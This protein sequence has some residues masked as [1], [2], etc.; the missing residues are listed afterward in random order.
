MSPV[1]FSPPRCPKPAL[2][3]EIDRHR[4]GASQHSGDIFE[5]SSVGTH[6]AFHTRKRVETGYGRWLSWLSVNGYLD[7]NSSPGDRV[8]PERVTRY[9]A[10]LQAVN[11][12]NTVLS[13]IQE[14]YLALTVVVP[15]HDWTWIHKIESRLKR[16]ATRVR[17]RRTGLSSSNRL[18]SLGL[19]LMTE[20]ERP[21][22]STPVEQAVQYRD[23]LMIS[24]LAARP[25]RRHNFATMEIGHHLVKQDDGYWIR[26]EATETKTHVPIEAPFPAA[27]V[28]YLERYL[29]H[30]R[31]LLAEC[32]GYWR[33]MRIGPLPSALWVS[34]HGTA[35]AEVAISSRF[36]KLTTD[37]LGP[38]LTMQRFRES[39]A[40]SIA[41][42][43]PEHV[44]ITM[45]ILG[46]TTLRTSE[47]HYN[48]ATSL[49]AIRRYQARILELRRSLAGRSGRSDLRRQAKVVT[50]TGLR[51]TMPSKED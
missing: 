42:E 35:M 9:V 21:S 18:Y 23:G 10:A 51:S 1:R 36:K 16:T 14:L 41:I 45:C 46:H 29:S 17:N 12:P 15:D 20:A 5:P 39:A 19:K 49:Q 26:F 27:L 4:W 24:L 7:S 3:P 38:R 34:Q 32:S 13:R 37:R 22:T 2:W 30:Y 40:T 47:R 50:S 43:D 31:P 44:R 8:K 33:R 11:A 6:W 28:A 48:H 25:L